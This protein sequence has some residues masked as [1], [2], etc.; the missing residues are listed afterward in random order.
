MD[1]WAKFCATPGASD[2]KVLPIGGRRK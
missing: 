1:D 2:G